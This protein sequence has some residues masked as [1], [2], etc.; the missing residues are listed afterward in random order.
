ML[1][2]LR[3]D[4]PEFVGAAYQGYMGLMPNREKLTGLYMMVSHKVVMPAQAGIQRNGNLLK[5]LDSRFR[6]NDNLKRFLTFCEAIIYDEVAKS[7]WNGYAKCSIS[8]ARW[9][10]ESGGVHK[11]RR[12]LRDPAATREIGL[13]ATP[14][15]FTPVRAA[16]A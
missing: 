15:E 12:A 1:H 4:L 14:S 16:P 13:F 3:F 11:V 2:T 5:I 8:K 6:G 10:R 7:I 9:C